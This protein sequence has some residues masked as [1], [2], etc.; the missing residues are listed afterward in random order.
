MLKIVKGELNP[1]AVWKFYTTHLLIFSST[2]FSD[3][4][5]TKDSLCVVK[6]RSGVD[7]YIAILPAAREGLNPIHLHYK[8]NT[9]DRNFAFYSDQLGMYAAAAHSESIVSPYYQYR[10]DVVSVNMMAGFDDKLMRGQQLMN[11]IDS[12]HAVQRLVFE[13]SEG[14]RHLLTTDAETIAKGGSESASLIALKSD[15]DIAKLMRTDF[16]GIGMLPN[17]QDRKSMMTIAPCIFVVPPEGC[18][19]YCAEP[20]HKVNLDCGFDD[21]V[22]NV[23]II[24]IRT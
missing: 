5:I 12:A 23:D 8:V 17:K 10:H 19:N 13:R 24:S 7:E 2:K 11:T 4:G 6:N 1:F 9:N 16:S 3:L 14:Q 22:L 21:R 18:S 20:T 15:P